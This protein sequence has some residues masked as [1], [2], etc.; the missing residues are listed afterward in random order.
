MG[1]SVVFRF[2]DNRDRIPRAISLLLVTMLILSIAIPVFGIPQVLAQDGGPD[3]VPMFRGNPART[4]ELPGPGPDPA[5]PIVELWSFP[6]GAEIISAPVVVDGVVYA[7]SRDG[8]LYA[9][10]AISGQFIWSVAVDANESSPTVADG[11]VYIGSYNGLHAVDAATGQQLWFAGDD[12]R[13]IE[14]SPVVVDGVVYAGSGLGLM[15]V[16]AVSGQELWRLDPFGLDIG[17][18]GS[19]PAVVDGVV[20][21]A[22]KSLQLF[23]IDAATGELRWKF[24]AGDWNNEYPTTPAVVDGTVYIA[25]NYD[26]QLYAIETTSGQKVWSTD[27]SGRRDGAPTSYESAPAVAGG[28]VYAAGGSN[29]LYALDAATG[30]ERWVFPAEPTV[31]FAPPIV[32]DSIVYAGSEAGL[33]A[34]DADGQELWSFSTGDR[35]RSSP[36]VVD[37]VIYF[38]SGNAIHALSN[39]TPAMRTA[40]AEAD[41]A[42]TAQAH[43]DQTATAEA[44]ASATAQAHVNETATAIAGITATAQAYIDATATT[45]AGATATAQANVMATAQAIQLSWENYFWT[46]IY[47]AF[48]TAVAEFPGM[49]VDRTSRIRIAESYVPEGASHIAYYPVPIAGGT[50]SAMVL[51]AVFPSKDDADAAMENIS[52]GLL[53]SGWSSQDGKGLKHNHVCLTVS[54]SSSSEALC[55]MTRDDALIISY[56]TI[57]QPNPDAALLNAVDLA[58]AMNDAYNQVKR[59]E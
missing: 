10:D 51:L 41:A 18:A 30:E 28:M 39:P 12:F 21:I 2:W 53:R 29:G 57:G 56:S 9:I 27:I 42:A 14:S 22:H 40:T 25:N 45:I 31:R 46:D 20:Y 50:A 33:F 34:I 48:S 44:H 3:D 58:N 35:I 15:A 6:T 7:G 38:A 55:Y 4:G 52:G 43:L 36:A 59:P 47:G 26:D 19:S 23:A 37:G 17:R 11:I 49:S 13:A 24:E 16:D 54:Y 8:N 32:V 5:E 1:N